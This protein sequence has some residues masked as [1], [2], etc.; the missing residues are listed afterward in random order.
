MQRIA[1]PP[2]S[3]WRD[4]LNSQ[5]FTF[6]SIAEVGNDQSAATS[7]FLY[8]R[9]DVAYRFNEGQ[10]ET[11]YEA[12]KELHRMCLDLAADLISRGDLGR[13]FLPASAQVLVEESWRRADPY[14][15]GRFDLSWNGDGEPK[16]LEY[17]A[18]TPTSIV[19]SAVAQWYWKVDVQPELDQFNSLHEALV[20]RLRDIAQQRGIR[21]LH[22]AG[23]YDVQEDVGN[24]EYMAEVAV[25]AGLQP[26]MLDVRDIGVTASGRFVDAADQHIDACFK[27]YPW[28]WLI[29]EEYAQ[30]VGKAPTQWLEPIWKLMLSNKAM[31]PLLW[32]RFAGHPNL[33]PSYFDAEQFTHAHPNQRYVR[34]PVF[35]REGANVSFIEK[36][37]L[38]L[39]TGGPYGEEGYVYQAF[40][41]VAAFAAPE[42]TSWHGPQSAMHAVIGSWIVGD[43]PCGIDIREDVSPVTKNT[44][45][46]VPHYF[47]P[48][49]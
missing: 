27:L 15:Y 39:E 43:E 28:E 25:Q 14:L 24:L 44:A 7:K 30:Y 47:V 4:R 10:V 1:H 3:D 31:L 2:R 34:K 35:S 32:E 16:L 36:G 26:S 12:T 29:H 46:F 11:L 49:A 19:E 21:T 41:P 23:M 6:H 38:L 5:G 22:L 40:A 13:L 45:Y 37:E 18:D 8:W 9:E 48:E 42:E 33:L 17:N 20:A